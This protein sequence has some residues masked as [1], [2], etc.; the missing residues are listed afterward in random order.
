MNELHGAAVY[1]NNSE[2]VEN[3]IKGLEEEKGSN[4]FLDIAKVLTDT[5]DGSHPTGLQWA[6]L[7]GHFDVVKHLIQEG[8]FQVLE[9]FSYF[10]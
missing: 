8:R 2:L 6:V 10:A 4:D 7:N 5:Q 1:A 3:L 9:N